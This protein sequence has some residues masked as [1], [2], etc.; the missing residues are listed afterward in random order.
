[1][2]KYMTVDEN[3]YSVF[4]ETCYCCKKDKKCKL[5]DKRLV[6]KKCNHIEDKIEEK[7]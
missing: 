7:I 2:S 1:M 5:I 3:G 4:K 6:C